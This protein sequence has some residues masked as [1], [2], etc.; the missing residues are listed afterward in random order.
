MMITARIEDYLKEIFILENTGRDITVGDVAKR[1]GIS[2][3]TVTIAVQHLVQA[4]M[5]THKRYGFL[6]LTPEGRRKGLLVYRRYEGLRAFFHEL[7]GVDRDHSSEMACDMEH[8]I[9]TVTGDKFYALLEYFRRARADKE[10]WADELFN[11]M[12]IQVLL[13]NPLSV[14]EGGEK[15]FITRLT[16]E[17]P[18]KDRLQGKGFKP[19]T[20][21]RCLHTSEADSL[22]VSLNGRRWTIPLKEA[23]TIWLRMA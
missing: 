15:G 18:L 8:C 20:L 5:L 22:R 16:A 1:L 7:L 2:R 21:V 23:A 19:G 3:S 10:P 17:K 4:K 6:Y 9:D 12:E 14:L 11:A 13:L